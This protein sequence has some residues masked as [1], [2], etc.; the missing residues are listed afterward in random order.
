MIP[1]PI[2]RDLLEQAVENCYTISEFDDRNFIVGRAGTTEATTR[3]PTLQI[4]ISFELGDAAEKSVLWKSDQ[5]FVCFD[6]TH[7]AIGG[8]GTSQPKIALADPDATR[9]LREAIDTE[10]KIIPP[11]DDGP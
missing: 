6:N 7:I 8:V 11:L 2:F 3:V 5:I 9:K 4:A 1:E 10:F